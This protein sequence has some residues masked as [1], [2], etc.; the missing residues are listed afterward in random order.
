MRPLPAVWVAVLLLV[1]LAFVTGGLQAEE[2]QAS[3]DAAITDRVERAL[4]RDRALEKMDIKVETHG[5]VVRLTGFVR[6]LEDIA[7]AGKLARKVRGVAAVKNGLRV[8]NRPSRA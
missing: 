3:V 6:S 7:K 8:E 1:A 5:A 4:G 2:Q